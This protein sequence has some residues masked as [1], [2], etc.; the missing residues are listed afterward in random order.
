MRRA[1]FLLPLLVGCA[2]APRTGAGGYLGLVQLHP[3]LFEGQAKPPAAAD[4]L[5]VH[6]AGTETITG[7]KTFTAATTTLTGDL[8]LAT[9]KFLYLD[10]TGHT[11]GLAWDGSTLQIYGTTS[12][13]NVLS[14]VTSVASPTY[15]ASAA[16][17]SNGFACTA[18]GCRVDFGPGL[19]DYMTSDSSQIIVGGPIN[20]G[21]NA[22]S[23]SVSSA[24]NIDLNGASYIQSSSA[25]VAVRINDAEGLVIL[26]KALVTCTAALEWTEANDALSGVATG[27]RSKKCL[28]TSNGSST[29]AWQNTTTG[30]IGTS[31]TCGTE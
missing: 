20:V 18:T 10:G 6:K 1:L 22:D 24:G 21:S 28:C 26:P 8:Q 12:V 27:K 11:K 4:S 3:E 13:N 25:G 9:S 17:G 31:T 5:A 19:R 23:L 15:T 30:T 14:V 29:Y 16:S 7:A 2:T